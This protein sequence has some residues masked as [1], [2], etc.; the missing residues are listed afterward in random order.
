M[1]ARATRYIPH[2]NGRLYALG[3]LIMFGLLLADPLPADEIRAQLTP[4]HQA[5]LA[6]GI[7]A[8]IAEIGLREGDSFHQD[9]TLVHLDCALVD[10]QRARTQAELAQTEHSLSSK[11]RL[12]ELQ[13]G[14]QL[15]VL[16][17]QAQRDKA[18]AEDQVSQVTQRHCQINAPFD[19]RV[20]EIRVNANEWVQ[21]GTPLLDILDHR[22]PE[23]EFIA[24]AHWLRWIKPDWPFQLQV[25]AL[26]RTYPARIR[27]IGARV[28]PVSQSVRLYGELDGQYPELIPGMSGRVIIQPPATAQTAVESTP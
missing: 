23:L 3:G 22:H 24:P 13:S 17:A 11:K 6:A 10:A 21:V 4:R 26:N 5:S 8:R 1:N 9:Q 25:E 28:D 27:R 12:L 18:A 2:H 19:G 16:L 7:S 14:N 20:A 15:E